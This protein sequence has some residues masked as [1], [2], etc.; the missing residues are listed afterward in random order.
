MTGK[1]QTRSR[2]TGDVE[3]GQVNGSWVPSGSAGYEGY[4][5]TQLLFNKA[6]PA[7]A[8]N[9]VTRAD[10]PAPIVIEKLA[11]RPAVSRNVSSSDSMRSSL[12]F[13]VLSD[14]RMQAA[15]RLAQRDV[16][17]RRHEAV[18]PSSPRETP[19]GHGQ[20]KAAIDGHPTAA[21]P[22]REETGSRSGAQ[23]LVHAPQKLP[24]SLVNVHG[25]SP[26]TRDAGPLP[27]PSGQEAKL[28]Q[29][30]G[31]L[32]KELETYI[33]RIEELANRGQHIE[34][35][36]DPEEERRVEIRRQEQA[37][38]SARIIYALQR[39][40]KEIQE[41]LDKL[42]SQKIR[43]TKKSRAVDRLTAAHRG[44]VRALQVFISQLPDQSERKMP[45]HYRE[46]GHLIRQL[47]LCSAKVEA[48]QGSSVPQ[49]AI[50]ILQKVEALDSALSKQEKA[51]ATESRADSVSPL[52]SLGGRKRIASPP[53]GPRSGATRGPGRP[54]QP[55]ARKKNVPDR[56]L[57]AAW[58]KGL[59]RE[60]VLRA[61]LDKLIR[62][63]G[64]GGGASR[65][66]GGPLRPEKTQKPVPTQDGRFQKPTVSS[67]QKEALL[68]P[69]ASFVPWMPTS[70]HASPPQ[71]AQPKGPQPRGTQPRCLFAQLLEPEGQGEQEQR[72]S[73]SAQ[74]PQGPDAERRREGH[75]EAVRQEVSSPTLWAERAEREAR[76][77]LQPL[78]DQ[79]QQ[80]Q[81]SWDRKAGSLRHRLCEQAA[82]RATANADLLSEALLEDVLE[83][84]ARALR[85]TERDQELEQEALLTL[86]APTVESMLL[87]MEEMEKDQEAVR[88]RLAGISYADLPLPD[89]GDV[90]VPGRSSPLPLCVSRPLRS[91]AAAVE[92]LLQGPVETGAASDTSVAENPSPL[93][94]PSEPARPIT[95]QRAGAILLSLPISMQRSV[96]AYRQDHESYLH[97]VS[98]E[99]V[100]SF[101]PWAIADCLA[102]ELMDEAL[103]D[104]A[105]EFQDV[106]EEYAEAVFTSEF[107]QPHHSPTTS[108]FAGGSQ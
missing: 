93:P 73:L 96:Q 61:G 33:Q 108:H 83:D 55:G 42:R 68:P 29:E 25:L 30:I 34:G 80:I 48:G 31:R 43:H 63:R 7:S 67:M 84:T 40:V 44:A 101:N 51:G 64:Q 19:K 14:E 28:S 16:R 100:G 72:G 91:G 17:R 88:L 20:S 27:K 57:T 106:C 79:A 60:E 98:H 37:A 85:V 62:A 13:S 65:V 50:D 56:R 8:A 94:R 2:L 95:V 54:P 46:L 12:C 102:E 99:T 6:L 105:A 78:L 103:A 3:P 82:D 87:R 23:V 4:S 1:F 86:Q 71:L 66:Q 9:R 97:L 11:A 69:K 21:G 41:D 81:E 47:S 89:K 22:E 53:R 59:D 5:R 24:L 39:Q 32:Q 70:P 18:Q 38:R 90:T 75:G 35:R 49:T 107:L 74:G 92:V 45:A 15:V 58:P 52:R 76:E 36:L 10:S 104:V 77:R 26:P